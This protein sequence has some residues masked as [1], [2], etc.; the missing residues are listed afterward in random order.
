[1]PINTSPGK[2]SSPSPAHPPLSKMFI[3]GL[4]SRTTEGT[5]AFIQKTYI[6]TSSSSA[7]SSTA[8][9]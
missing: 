2:P 5:L 8:S 9:S 3:G 1:M 7:R 4:S 6:S